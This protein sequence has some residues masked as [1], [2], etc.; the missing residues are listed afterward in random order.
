MA[1][2]AMNG[3]AP[4]TLPARHVA[5]VVVGNA[6]EFYDFLTYAFFA[7]YIGNAFFPSHDAAASLLASLATFGAGFLTRPIGAIVIGSMGDRIG[8]KPA[9]M[10]SFA[11]MGVAILGLSLTPSYARIG[12]AAPILVILFR[13]LQGF[14]L[15]GDVGPTTAFLIEA[16][17][18]ASRGFYASMQGASQRLSAMISG[19]VGTA[20]AIQLNAQQLQDWGWRAAMLIG[21]AIVPFGLIVRRSLPETL[22]AA[23]DAALAPDA[24][25]GT[26]TLSATLLPHT[27][28]IVLGLLL[29]GASTIGVYVVSFMTTY[30]LTTL[31]LGA[32]ASFGVT[33]VTSMAGFA[34]A[35]LGGV[36]SDRIGRKPVMIGPGIVAILSIIPAFWLITHHGGVAT[37]YLAMFWISF[38]SGLSTGIAIIVLT[39]LLPAKIRAGTMATVYAIAISIFGGSTQF[40][41][42]WLMDKTGSP[43]VPGYYW[44][45][46]YAI[47]LVAMLLVNESAPVKLLKPMRDL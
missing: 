46:A 5:A 8:R 38:W 42:K 9:M 7:V 39:E 1:D 11:L 47:G 4:V 35:L 25:R 16:A 12:I 23:D 33:A 24:T 3:S 36:W 15:G 14:A 21:V 45:A 27:K 19:L 32:V 22:H 30:A 2:I 37:F 43:M 20:L 13:L 34:A 6:L 26:L 18:P 28:T 40:L 29:L 17:P 44:T 10:L 41:V 31:H